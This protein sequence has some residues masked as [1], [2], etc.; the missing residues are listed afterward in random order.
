[1]LGNAY[2]SVDEIITAASQELRDAGFTHGIQRPVYLSAAQRGLEQMNN[3]TSF[4]KKMFFAEIPDNLIIDL[5]GDMTG[6]DQVYLFNGDTCN[7]STSTIMFIK[8]NMWHQ[9][10]EGYIANNKGRNNDPLQYSFSWSET[11]PNCLY[12]GGE[13]NGKLYLAPSCRRY[14]RLMIPYVGLGVDCFGEDFKVPHWAREAITDYVIHRVAL[15]MERDDPQFLA[16]VINRKENELKSPTGSWYTAIT[17]YK[18][19][20]KKGRYD[21]NAY[22]YKFG[23]LQ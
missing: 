13:Y 22:N 11:P 23:H 14:D 16:R 5:P 4:F 6:K 10:G 19:L 18:K 21:S 3:R 2:I 7:I 12:F 1:M 20:D 9:G 17:D 15:M 8:P